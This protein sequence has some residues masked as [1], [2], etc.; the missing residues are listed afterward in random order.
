[1]RGPK[2]RDN[3]KEM[4]MGNGKEI[5]NGYLLHPKKDKPLEMLAVTTGSI[6]YMQITKVNG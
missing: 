3:P 6:S 5:N 4:A 1:M 2:E